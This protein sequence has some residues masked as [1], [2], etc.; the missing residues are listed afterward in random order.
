VKRLR[1]VVAQTGLG[2]PAER[3]LEALLELLA[4][5][6]EA[7]TSVRAPAEAV[8][9]HIADSLAALPF[10]GP[11]RPDA[12]ADVGSGAGFPGLPLAIALS[13]SSVDLIES[14]TRKCRFLERAI[15]A[16]GAANARVVCE[17]VEDWAR[18]EG[19]E[20]Y[21]LVTARAVAPLATLIE[22]A[23]PLL[24]EHGWLVAWKGARDQGEETQAAA[25][26]HVLGMSPIATHQVKPFADA[27]QRHLHLFEKIGPTPDGVPRRSGMARK[28]PFGTES[29]GSN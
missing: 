2:E 15:R 23:S 25:A 26:A 3:R 12:I 18:G 13:D 20:C 19:A 14:T 9:T 8:D 27:R 22:Y 17:R 21:A 24:R 5:D 16:A 29:S 7:P 4:R 1:D 11:R 6:P 28:K 10:L